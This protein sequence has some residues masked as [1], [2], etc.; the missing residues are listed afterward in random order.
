M[1]RVE[2]DPAAVRPGLTVQPITHTSMAMGKP[3]RHELVIEGMDDLGQRVKLS[4]RPAEFAR[5]RAV[6]EEH[7]G[8]EM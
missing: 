1:P 6:G 8:G 7:F 4:L 3:E 2:G 5:L